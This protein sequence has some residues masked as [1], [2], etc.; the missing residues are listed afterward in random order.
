[1]DKLREQASLKLTNQRRTQVSA[2]TTGG[3]NPCL[4][5][6]PPVRP[7]S[8]SPRV[9]NNNCIL[10]VPKWGKGDQCPTVT[11]GNGDALGA[12]FDP[13]PPAEVIESPLCHRLN[14]FPISV[15]CCAD[16]VVTSKSQ[17]PN[18]PPSRPD[19]GDFKP[20]QQS[21][22]QMTHNLTLTY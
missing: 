10:V 22:M 20:K 11:D 14:Q 4:Q 3:G 19:N 13:Q 15:W 8:I 6:P 17:V 9:V 5:P 2:A 16:I 18:V 1:L 7:P 12:T 21:T